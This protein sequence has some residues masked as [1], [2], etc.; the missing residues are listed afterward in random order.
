MLYRLF[1][2]LLAVGF[3]LLVDWATPFGVI[4]GVIY[5]ALVAWSFALIDKTVAPRRP[6]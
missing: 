2:L 1:W 5:F 3:V 6:E 4:A